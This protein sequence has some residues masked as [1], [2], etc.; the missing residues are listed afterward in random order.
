MCFHFN[1]KKM[2]F[3]KVFAASNSDTEWESVVSPIT[4]MMDSLL[5]PMLI[6]VGSIGAIYCIIVGI[7]FA[8]AEDGQEREKAKTALKNACVGFLFIFILIATLK[9]S[10]KPLAHWVKQTADYMT[11][12]DS[13]DINDEKNKDDE[14]NN[15]FT[16]GTGQVPNVNSNDNANTISGGEN[17][18]NPDQND[19]NKDTT[20]APVMPWESLLTWKPGWEVFRTFYSMDAEYPKLMADFAY[21]VEYDWR[22]NQTITYDEY[23]FLTSWL[24]ARYHWIEMY[25][26]GQPQEIKGNPNSLLRNIKT[27]DAYEVVKRFLTT[28]NFELNFHDIADI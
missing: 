1:F 11:S 4:D 3:S 27:K 5:V 7:K 6:L 21:V 2:L 26:N 12:Q 19:K 23:K 25:Y 18:Q 24:N 9:T 8:K 15:G 22:I 13:I 17:L 14:K 10:I 16:P 20:P 28:I